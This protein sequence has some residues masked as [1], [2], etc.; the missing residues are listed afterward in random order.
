M[1]R[2]DFAFVSKSSWQGFP[3]KTNEWDVI[4]NWA[5]EVVS[6]SNSA[7]EMIGKVEEY[8]AA[9]VELVWLIYTST[10]CVY[11]YSSPA[12]IAVFKPGESVTAAPVLSELTIRVTELFESIV[13][14]E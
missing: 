10:P 2:P 1:R 9:G 4:P 12:D 11:V 5:V 14:I 3:P 7:D 13:P 8:F 6:P